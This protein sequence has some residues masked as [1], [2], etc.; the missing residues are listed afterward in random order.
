[1]TGKEL[2]LKAIKCEEVSRI[3][4][5]PFVGCHAAYLLDVSAEDYFKSADLIHKGALKAAELYRPDGLPAV[6]DL[7]VE[8]EAL[9]CAVQF[10]TKN[11]PAVMS[12][13][14]EDNPDLNNLKIPDG[15]EGRYPVVMDAV[16]RIVASLGN[17]IAIYGLIT[18]PFTLGLHLRGTDIF[19]DMIDNPD[20]VKELLIF[21][22]QVCKATAKM[23]IEAGADIVA[24]VDP[25]TSQISSKD[26]QEFVHPA[27]K[28]VFD[29]IREQGRLSS[30]FVC[31]NARRNVEEMCKCGPDNISIDENIPLPYVK[32]VATQYGVSVGGNI[33]LTVTM[34]LGSPADNITDAANCCAIGGLKG[35]IL[36][37]G[38]DMPFATPKVN[39]QA[40]TAW[41]HGED[42]EFL[43]T[44]HGEGLVLEE[45]KLPNYANEK[46]VIVD[47]IT[48]DSDSCAP[49]KYMIEGVKVAATGLEDKL[50]FKEHRVKTPEGIGCMIALGVKNIPTIVI[51]GV[52]RYV[53]I[54]PGSHELRKTFL[55]EIASKGL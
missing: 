6:F 32:E 16:R 9:G 12:H 31:G 5:V 49:C 11:P 47:I 2:V 3:P 8:A 41:V 52:I 23:Y 38:C 34:L 14:L 51:D 13:P 44:H 4:W 27:G 29:F 46:K 48:L 45:Y 43:A 18:G 21:C 35:Y 19:Y 7:Q 54:I 40:I 17:Q 26:F 50:E 55:D 24:V 1:M 33:Q 39:V 30:F 37:P 15:T 20:Y 28:E 22:A 53:S 10:S 36:S 25:M 42:A